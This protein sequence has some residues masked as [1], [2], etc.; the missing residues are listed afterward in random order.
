MTNQITVLIADDHPVVRQ[1]IA[2]LLSVHDDLLVAG[3]AA[4]GDEALRLAAELKPDVLLL[5]LKLPVLDGVAAAA[6]P[7][8][9]DPRPGTHQRRGQDP[10]RT[11][12]AGR[13]GRVPLQGRGPGR[14]GPGHPLGP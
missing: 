9:P 12:A 4:D 14:A 1:G 7:I 10:G 8:R 2:V 6:E 11:R 3:E 13:R 5:D